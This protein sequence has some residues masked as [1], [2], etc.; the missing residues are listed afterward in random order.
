MLWWGGPGSSVQILRLSCHLACLLWSLSSCSCP[1][2][3]SK[4]NI[5]GTRPEVG[6][7]AQ[8]VTVDWGLA[9]GLLDQGQQAQKDASS[10][11]SC[12]WGKAY[13]LHFTR[14]HLKTAVWRYRDFLPGGSATS[15]IC[16]G[17]GVETPSH[18]CHAT[19][20]PFEVGCAHPI[21]QIGNEGWR[22]V[23]LLPRS[24]VRDT[25]ARLFLGS[26]RESFLVKTFSSEA[27]SPVRAEDAHR[28]GGHPNN[29]QDQHYRGWLWLP[30]SW[31]Q[32]GARSGPEVL[33]LHVGSARPLSQAVSSRVRKRALRVGPGGLALAAG[34]GE[35]PC[36]V[37]SAGASVFS[38]PGLPGGFLP[39][40]LTLGTGDFGARAWPSGSSL[41]TTGSERDT[42][43]ALVPRSPSWRR[44]QSRHCRP[45]RSG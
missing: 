45:S 1:G 12:V 17:P 29:T 36:D 2:D 14:C 35:G 23:E 15:P 38:G 19:Q 24:P 6:E 20:Q 42:V 5:P 30:S 4:H 43:P 44:M 31:G 27:G 10:R 16:L 32:G 28:T 41:A 26:S 7:A 40:L 9:W 21:L 34:A 11:L 22:E 25:S 3:S 37:F 8:E 39:G 13:H 33:W 18:G